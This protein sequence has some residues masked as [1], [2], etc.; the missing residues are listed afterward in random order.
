MVD[1]YLHSK[2]GED[3]VECVNETIE[4]EKISKCICFGH[5]LVW[6]FTKRRPDFQEVCQLVA[7]LHKSAFISSP[8]VEESYSPC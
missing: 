4:N 6:A 1:E 3:V 2:R 5:S 7:S 8:E